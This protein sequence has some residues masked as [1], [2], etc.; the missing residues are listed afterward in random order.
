MELAGFLLIAEE[1]SGEGEVSEEEGGG[2]GRVPRIQPR[3]SSLL[4]RS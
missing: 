1:K 3:C 2:G 4:A